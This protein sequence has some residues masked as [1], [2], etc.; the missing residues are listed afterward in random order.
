MVYVGVYVARILLAMS[1]MEADWWWCVS[2]TLAGGAGFG[3][4]LNALVH[5]I[6]DFTCNSAIWSNQGAL[7]VEFMG[8]DY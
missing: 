4:I 7:C 2:V 6:Y 3:Y 5:A 1:E 8:S